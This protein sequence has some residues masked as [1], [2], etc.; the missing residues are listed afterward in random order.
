MIS[1]TSFSKQMVSLLISHINSTEHWLENTAIRLLIMTVFLDLQK[2]FDSVDH[3]ILI[4]KLCK[5]GI[6]GKERK[7]FN[8]YLNGR[9][10]FFS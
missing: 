2:A 6:K 9:K 1:Y 10:Q 3:I 8:S 4:D 5:D 7:W